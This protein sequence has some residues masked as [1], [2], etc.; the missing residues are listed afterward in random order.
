MFAVY[1]FD[2]RS[3]IHRYLFTP[4]LRNAV[5]AET[6]HQVAVKVLRSGL[7]PR[8]HLPDSDVL[9]TKVS[10]PIAFAK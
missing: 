8:D 9:A 10:V 1:Y 7:G 6:S 2:A 3:A 5:D 4:I